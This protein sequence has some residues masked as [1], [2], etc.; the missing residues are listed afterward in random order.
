M[1]QVFLFFRFF[2]QPKLLAGCF[3]SFAASMWLSLSIYA[4]PNPAEAST[5]SELLR[6]KAVFSLSDRDF[7]S[8]LEN[9]DAAVEADSDD[10]TSRYYRGIA[11]S[12]LGR[13]AQ[14]AEDLDAARKSGEESDGLVYELG[15]AYYRQELF[16]QAAEAFELSMAAHPEHAPSAYYLGLVHYRLKNYSECLPPLGRAAD[17]DEEFGASSSYLSADALIKLNRGDEAEDNLKSALAR[18]PESVYAGS[19]AALLDGIKAS[20]QKQKRLDLELSAG[21]NYDN[22]VGLFPDDQPL[23]DGID[24]EK[25]LRLQL[26]MDSR[27]HL[28]KKSPNSFS[29]GYRLFQSLHRDLDKYDVR[30]HTLSADFKRSSKFIQWGAAYQFTDSVLDN[31]DYMRVHA[32]APNL[33]LN[34]GGA[35]ASLLKLQWRDN[36][37]LSEDQTDKNGNS[38]SINYRH[39]WFGRD[40]TN[41]NFYAGLAADWESAQDSEFDQTSRG[42]EV[43][44][45]R[46]FGQWL[47]KGTLSYRRKDYPDAE[48]KRS[49]HHTEIGVYAVRPLG[50]RIE[51]ESAFIHIQNPSSE[52]DFDYDRSILSMTLRWRR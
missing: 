17:L 8:A 36:N 47:F 13:Y 12:R 32:V 30:N 45:Q 28:L 44:G 41:R 37:Y 19:M 14:A 23:A 10:A 4:F 24:S 16:T 22:N 5:A 29:L 31:S 34:H 48:S 27:F 40:Q 26:A 35:R 38:R 6:T 50:R 51:V 11:L 33:A 7:P 25:D 1:N 9:L 49:D 52:K 21:V 20:R 15:Y 42:F 43:G 39:Y 2:K 46:A 18:W 3:F